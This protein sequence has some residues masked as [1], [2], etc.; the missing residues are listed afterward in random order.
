MNI[1]IFGKSV[2]QV[3]DTGT[4]VLD[5]TVLNHFCVPVLFASECHQ[6]VLKNVNITF[7]GNTGTPGMF[8][9]SPIL[10]RYSS[11]SGT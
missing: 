3:P 11:I 10:M 5:N 4:R 9:S 1:K 7:S 8:Q 2:L 6:H